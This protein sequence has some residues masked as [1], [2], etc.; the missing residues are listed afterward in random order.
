M[1]I[2]T[3]SWIVILAGCP[4]IDEVH[5]WDRDGVPDNEDCA[6]QD[7][8]AYPGAVEDCEDEIDNDCNNAVDC[9]DDHCRYHPDCESDIDSDDDAVDDDT[10]DDDS[11]SSD[12]DTGDDDDAGD[13]DTAVQVAHIVLESTTLDDTIGGDGD[14]LMEA[15]E[16]ITMT[17]VVRN[18]GG[19]STTSTIIG[20]YSLDATQS[21]AAAQLLTKAVSYN[22]GQPIEPGETADH[23]PAFSFGV[24]DDAESGQVLIF[25]V[26]VADDSGRTWELQTEALAVEE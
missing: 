16:G 3:L 7:P 10:G 4:Q 21:T 20:D 19:Q 12:D 8:Y 14:G 25:D 26:V 11:A 23:D 1:R 24:S 6:P 13:D 17:V 9:H 5:D 22:D 2:C 18:D 15:G